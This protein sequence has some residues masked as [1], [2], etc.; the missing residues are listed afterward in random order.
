MRCYSPDDH[1]AVEEE[2]GDVGEQLDDEELHPE[3]V[4]LDVE[5]VGPQLRPLHVVPA[6]V[7]PRL[8]VSVVDPHHPDAQMKNY[9]TFYQYAFGK[10]GLRGPPINDVRPEGGQ[11]L[12]QKLTTACI[13]RLL[14]CDSDM[15]DMKSQNFA[16]V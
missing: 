5:L 14:E 13:I 7:L 16:D 6:H 15:K 4:D 3:D 9:S 8:R 11:R 2:Y 1:D 10:W 12:A